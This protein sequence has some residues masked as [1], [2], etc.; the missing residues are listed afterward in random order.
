MDDESSALLSG[1]KS[2]VGLTDKPRSYVVVGPTA[3]GKSS[4][5]MELATQHA[6]EIVS[7]DSVQIYRGFN[8]GSA[9]PSVQDVAQV[10]HHM[11]DFKDWHEEFD[12]RMFAR[13]AKLVVA[14]IRSRG[15]LPILVGGTGLYLRALWGAAFH[16]DL[17][18]DEALRKTLESLT[19][20]E[21]ML[22]LQEKDPQRASELHV[23]D[24]F[25]LLRALEL[26][27][28]M[29]GPIA[30][31]R[32]APPEE[33]RDGA[34]VIYLKPER[35][36]LHQR[37]ELRADKMLAE[38]LIEEVRGLLAAGVDP[39]CKPMQAIAYKQVVEF[40]RGELSRE[41]LAD[42]VKAATRQYAKRQVTWFGKLAVDEVR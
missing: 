3:S 2:R 20:E 10:R 36:V 6:G 24:R 27:T 16:H 41:E 12:A 7:F 15:K 40:L 31:N 17:P 4:L 21:M 29:G 25:R 38:G 5:A 42:R 13:E 33:D 8:I 9:K 22:R 28:L 23:N 11:V 19:N 34:Y 39:G 37:I 32:G 14:D 26:V 30:A 18:K 35:Q 1:E